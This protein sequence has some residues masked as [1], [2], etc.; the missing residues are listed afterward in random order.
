MEQN[1]NHNEISYIDFQLLTI[2]KNEILFRLFPTKRMEVVSN[3]D[4]TS[5]YVLTTNTK[6][7]I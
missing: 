7:K 6:R 3:S 1:N 2:V 4:T 5:F